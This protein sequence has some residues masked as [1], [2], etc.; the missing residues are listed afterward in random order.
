MSKR[1]GVFFLS[2]SNVNVLMEKDINSERL[3]KF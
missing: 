3:K 2:N 1:K